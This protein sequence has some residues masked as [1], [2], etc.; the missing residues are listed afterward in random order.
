MASTLNVQQQKM[1]DVAGVFRSIEIALEAS[2]L[3]GIVLR[4]KQVECIDHVLHGDDVLA[5][6]PTG[7]G[8][9][10]VFQ[11]LPFLLPVKDDNNIVI[12]IAPLTS[13]INDQ[14]ALLEDRGVS[15]GVLHV[16]Q[17]YDKI[18]SLLGED[19]KDD[20]ITIPTKIKSGQ[21]NLLFTHPEALLSADGRDLMSSDVYRRNVVGLVVDEAHCIEFW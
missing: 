8:K 4:P 11:L 1:A 7:Y 3:H 15:A 17:S 9:S 5:I 21:V 18:E 10:L 12:V 6:L 19:K 14:V 13:I 2:A 16:P 20:C